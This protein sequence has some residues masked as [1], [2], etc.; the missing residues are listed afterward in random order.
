MKSQE[1]AT[2]FEAH[3]G[4]GNW[5]YGLALCA[6]FFFVLTP[7]ANAELIRI[8]ATTFALR[9]ASGSTDLVGESGAGLLQNAKG[10][11]FA[12]VD[13]PTT[14]NV[15]RFSLVYRDFDTNF[16]IVAR[17]IKKKIALGGSAFDPPITMAKVRTGVAA[18]SNGVMRKATNV[19]TEPATPSAAFYFVELDVPA[20]TLQVLGVE[21][22]QKP[23]C[24]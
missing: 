23:S 1:I 8:S 24:P 18:A 4:V 22:I 5:M 21:I 16:Q 2:G 15:C 7:S 12:P 9:T 10:S 3:S 17:L 14:G 19:I 11:Y 6:A 13:F 20:T